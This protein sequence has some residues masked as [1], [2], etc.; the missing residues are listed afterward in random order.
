VFVGADVR[1]HYNLENLWSQ[2]LREGRRAAPA[3]P[4]GRVDPE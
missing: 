2:S 3:E 4:G 1:E